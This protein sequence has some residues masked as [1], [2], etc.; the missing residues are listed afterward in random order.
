MITTKE[1]TGKEVYGQKAPALDIIARDGANPMV[2]AF[3]YKAT[4][5][6]SAV[7]PSAESVRGSLSTLTLPEKERDV[8]KVPPPHST[9]E[10]EAI[11]SRAA[12]A[13]LLTTM[14]TTNDETGKEVYG[15]KTPVLDV[16]ARNGDNPMVSAFRYKAASVRSA[17]KKSAA[18]VRGSLSTITLP[19]IE[20]MVRD[21]LKQC[22][23]VQSQNV[24][25]KVFENNNKR[26]SLCRHKIN[27]KEKDR[28]IKMRDRRNLKAVKLSLEPQMFKSVASNFVPD[29]KMG[30]V[31]EDKSFL[32]GL[33]SDLLSGIKPL[34]E[35][36]KV[37]HEFPSFSGI[38][39][40]M[41]SLSS[42]WEFV[43]NSWNEVSLRSVNFFVMVSMIFTK[44][45]EKFK[46][47]A[48]DGIFDFVIT[49]VDVMLPAIVGVTDGLCA[50]LGFAEEKFHEYLEAIKCFFKYTVTDENEL[51][52]QSLEMD[53]YMIIV[54][55]CTVAA[56]G[57]DVSTN[58]LV[59]AVKNIL[60][61]DNKS[62]INYTLSSIFSSIAYVCRY[63]GEATDIEYFKT[64]GLDMPEEY[65]QMLVWERKSNRIKMR[66][67]DVKWEMHEIRL[68]SEFLTR[69]M[70]KRDKARSRREPIRRIHEN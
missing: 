36:V 58:T 43:K 28:T 33:V 35:G 30:I 53:A 61:Y 6:R 15:Q 16:R 69:M 46:N 27:V 20:Q 66:D 31:D 23:E 48:I 10:W 19:E 49:I 9:F 4:S 8:H 34:S 64:I 42:V 62:V 14:I 63:F 1:Q 67:P 45:Y 25:R 70:E 13:K 24:H 41:P 44:Y 47:N 7:K 57:F 22:S 29:L 59:S 65:N 12:P 54:G 50:F 32:K 68:M 56:S 3:R 39:S 18:S 52:A 37:V 5:V 11:F 17:A 38:F 55:F 26:R 60:K 2:S 51:Q 40:G 21:T